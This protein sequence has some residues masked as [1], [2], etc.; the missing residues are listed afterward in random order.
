MKHLN[1]R[2]ARSLLCA[3]FALSSA[4]AA[5][6]DDAKP[7]AASPAAATAAP[8]A[9]LDLA[10]DQ[11]RLI[12]GGTAG[13]G[14]LHFNGV[15]YAFTFKTASAGVGYRVVTAVTATGEVRGLKQ[16]GDFAGSYTASSNSAQVGS[17]DQDATWKNDKGVS[18]NLKEKIKGT[19][20]SLGAA[21]AKIELVKP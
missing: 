10:S 17:S 4:L 7:Q 13:K 19:G 8:S 3:A 16:I 15:D 1:A 5:A 21:E 20:L 9:T 2:V 18:I 11:V 14:T 12:M 6:A